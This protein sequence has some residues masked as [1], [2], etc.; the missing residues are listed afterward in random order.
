[1]KKASATLERLKKIQDE[2]KM[3]GKFTQDQQIDI[4]NRSQRIDA[5]IL[6]S[7]KKA[8]AYRRL[9]ERHDAKIERTELA[10]DIL[11]DNTRVLNDKFKVTQLFIEDLYKRIEQLGGHVLRLVQI[12]D[13][14]ESEKESGEAAHV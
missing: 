11:F 8:E 12:E 13:K 2:L 7:N 3:I 4:S 1:M 14:R 10:L 9:S 5:Q 6:I